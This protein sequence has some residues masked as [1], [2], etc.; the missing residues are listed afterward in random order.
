MFFKFLKNIF[1][2]SNIQKINE[3]LQ[4]IEPE[5]NLRVPIK[6]HV[7]D[8]LMPDQKT[9][10]Q[11]L[12][13]SSEPH[14]FHHISAL[15]DVHHKKGRRNPSGT[16]V[17]V[18]DHFLPQLVDTAP[19]CG[20]RLIKTPFDNENFP[21]EKI[22]ELFKT[23]ISTVPTKAYLGNYLPFQTIVDIS[24]K[25]SIALLKY[26]RK[27]LDEIE[28]TQNKGNM[29]EKEIP[30][31][32][33]LFSA[34]PE[35]FFRAGQ[36]RLGILGAAGNHFLDLMKIDEILDET[37]ARK[38]KIKKNQYLFMIH[39]GSGLFGQYASYFYTPK[40][41]EHTS[42][43]LM[44]RL[45]QSLFRGKNTDW[46]RK[47]KKDLL[48]YKTKKEF[49]QIP[50]DSEIGKNY[51]IAHRAAANH[52]FANRAMIQINIEKALEKV[53]GKK[54]TLPLIYDMTHISVTKEKHFNKEVYIHRNNTTRAFGPSKM[55]GIKI[56]EETGEPVFLPSSM[57][58]PAYLGAAL[59]GN[60]ET[61]C[62]SAH[63]TGRSKIA[64][65]EIPK[66]KEALFQKMANR[67][68]KLYNAASAGIIQQDASSY[69]DVEKALTGIEENKI[70]KPVAKMM[71]VAVLMY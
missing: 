29:F 39:T 66:D 43:K 12:E 45:G 52:G 36:F 24:R 49:Y 13:V 11:L 46:F 59:D 61:F 64:T 21:T 57:S 2:M 1:A 20:M 69:K 3:N 71:P 30:S 55:K 6:F 16:V 34:L 8:D 33:D 50:A 58:T 10:D 7:S 48:E 37:I 19:N 28:N 67:K 14:I 27:D 25:G 60:E 38:W 63:G 17:A 31:E 32:E 4:L 15:S 47:L 56:Y 53:S 22:D 5:N 68:V 9:I 70:M 65:S 62:S 35:V 54:Y 18:E 42:Q 40:I 23:L 26:F 51:F 44:L 41:K